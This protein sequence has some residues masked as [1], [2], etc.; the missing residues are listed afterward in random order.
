MRTIRCTDLY[1]DPARG[2]EVE[3][4]NNYRQ[5]WSNGF[6]EYI[7]SDDLGYNPIAA[8]PGNWNQIDP[9]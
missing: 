3:L 4:S 7:L 1:N 6:G 8:N 2:G 9:S 5:V